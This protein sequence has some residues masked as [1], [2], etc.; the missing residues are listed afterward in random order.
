MEAEAVTEAVVHHLYLKNSSGHIHIRAEHFKKWLRDLY[1]E[2]GTYTPP[3]ARDAEEA[4]GPDLIYVSA[5]GDTRGS[6]M[7]DSHPSRKVKH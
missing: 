7:E 6:G 2:E 3:K 1:W 4:G 5:W